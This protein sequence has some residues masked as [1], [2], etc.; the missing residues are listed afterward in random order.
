M[1]NFKETFKEEAN[2]LLN[3]L[4]STLLELEANP[5]DEEQRLSLFR[6]MH[7]IK[8]SAAMFGFEHTSTFAHTL[9]NCLESIK[10]GQAPFT[11]GIADLT[12]KARDHI[13]QLLDY[14]GD[15][16]EQLKT[17]S[18]ELEQAFTQTMEQLVPPAPG[19]HTDAA[20]RHAQ[21]A[22][23]KQSEQVTE[24]SANASSSAPGE[25]EQTGSM[26]SYRIDLSLHEDIYRNGTNPLLLLEELSE[27]GLFGAVPHLGNVPPLSELDPEKCLI[28]WTMFLTTNRPKEAIRDVFMFVEDD[29]NINIVEI[30]N[31]EEI[32]DTDSHE[33][34]KVGQ[35]LAD[36]GIIDAMQAE[37]AAANQKRIGEQLVEQ[38]VPQSEIDA[39]LLEQQHVRKSRERFQSELSASTIRVDSHK[40]DGLVDL[41]GELVTLQARIMS[42][43]RSIDNQD[44]NTIAEG[45][46]RLVDDLRDRTMNIRMVPVGTTFSKFRRLVRDLSE[47]LGKNVE[48]KT[49]GSETELDKTVIERLSEPL[50]HVVRNAVDH[51]IES[52]EVRKADGKPETGTVLLKA[53]HEGAN[54]VIEV[55]DDGGGLD[56]EKLRRKAEERG[57]SFDAGGDSG[58]YDIIFDSGFS[59]A[60]EVTEVSG[61]GVGMDVVRRQVEALGGS[62]HVESE[63]KKGSTFRL[64]IPLTL[65]IIDGLLVQVAGKYYV[66]P[67]NAVS[68]CLEFD[69]SEIDSSKGKYIR[70]RDRLL[71]YTRLRDIFR[72]SAE[73]TDHEQMVV[74]HGNDGDIGLV[75]DSVI[76]DHQTVIKDL[77]KMFR[78]IDGVSGATI[79]GDG[80]VALVCDITQLQR[81]VL[82]TG[83][84]SVHANDTADA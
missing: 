56:P 48:L 45:L 65:A 7:T 15:P 69:R 31:L 26:S 39:A 44:L 59:T 63:Q 1:E 62:V 20:G 27:L 25:D 57:L 23:S 34:K 33:Y 67:L 38:G 52:P 43:S 80:T 30:E 24:N 42:T 37:K 72:L 8:G 78:A 54:V 58:I 55:S 53:S 40:L 47:S 51:G 22:S 81:V 64:V 83:S 73:E 49:E 36:R 2:E 5:D 84:S 75:V 46:E 4:E 9:E 13:L 82:D 29:A 41:V 68:E 6:T 28:S 14:D 21:A 76:G 17:Y 32:G 60:T 77:G 16:P 70:N 12:L 18:R 11:A 10:S 19:V 66:F 35:I 79:L 61:R 3:K 50:V 71:P 74:V